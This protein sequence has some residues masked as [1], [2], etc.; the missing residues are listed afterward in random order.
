MGDSLL[1]E[2]AYMLAPR[3]Q[4]LEKP[5]VACHTRNVHNFIEIEVSLPSF[6]WPATGLC[7]EP[8][9]SSPRIPIQ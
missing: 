3:N 8:D 2:Y 5:T 7:P 9:E 6:Q 1:E 4:F